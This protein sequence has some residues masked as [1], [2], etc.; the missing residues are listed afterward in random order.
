MKVTVK[1]FGV[2][3]E[4]VGKSEEVLELEQGLS[5]KELKDQQIKKYQI[6]DAAS[7]QIAVNQNLNKEVELK[8]GDEVAFLPPFAG[9]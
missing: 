2:I 8:D 6:S 7:L 4:T 3:A 1:Y 5:V 9:G